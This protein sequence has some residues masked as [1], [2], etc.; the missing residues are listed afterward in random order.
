MI[1][2]YDWL[3]TDVCFQ[4]TLWQL[5]SCFWFF[6]TALCRFI[7]RCVFWLTAIHTMHSSWNCCTSLLLCV[8]FIFTYSKTCEFVVC[9]STSFLLQQKLS[10]SFTVATSIVKSHF[11]QFS[12][13][14]AWTK[15]TMMSICNRYF[16]FQ[17]YLSMRALK[18]NILV[19]H[20]QPP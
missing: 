11:K 7:P 17:Y 4:T 18:L 10:V 12:I 15:L 14:T 20:F 19:T 1:G 13:C 2:H 16:T 9:T 3:L 5:R 8:S 6:C